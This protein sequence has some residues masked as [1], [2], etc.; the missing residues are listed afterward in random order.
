MRANIQ[1]SMMSIKN[2]ELFGS[3]A[4]SIMNEITL[5]YMPLE[6]VL[7]ESMEL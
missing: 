1:Y 5:L 7:I 2:A 3:Y 4:D 6:E